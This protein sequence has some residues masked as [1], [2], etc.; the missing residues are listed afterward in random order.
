MQEGAARQESLSSRVDRLK[1]RERVSPCAA[2][3]EQRS[4]RQGIADENGRK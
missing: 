2:R 1:L 3:E 4:Q